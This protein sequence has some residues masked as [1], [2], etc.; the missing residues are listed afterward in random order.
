MNDFNIIT[1]ILL[2]VG[3]FV[4]RNQIKTRNKEIASLR[5]DI[6]E[7]RIWMEKLDE[8]AY[9]TEDLLPYPK[10]GE[11]PTDNPLDAYNDAVTEHKEWVIFLQ[12]FNRRTR[13]D[14]LC[15]TNRDV[16]M[17]ENKRRLEQFTSNLPNGRK[18]K[19]LALLKTTEEKE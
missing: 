6:A 18:E 4:F 15:R 16:D 14:P 1:I 13:L 10:L 11:S 19:F 12:L 9:E 2:I 5:A 17:D 8:A 3:F 7:L